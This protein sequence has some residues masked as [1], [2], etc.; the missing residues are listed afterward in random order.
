MQART[1]AQ[2]VPQPLPDTWDASPPRCGSRR[3]RCSS[4]PGRPRQP[5]RACSP[6]RCG[7]LRRWHL[8]TPPSRRL[9]RHRTGLRR[10]PPATHW[11]RQQATGRHQVQRRTAAAAAAPAVG[12]QRAAG[13]AA[14]AAACASVALAAQ[15]P[16]CRA[17][18]WQ[19]C[20][21]RICMV[22]S[23]RWLRCSEILAPLARAW[24]SGSGPLAHQSTIQM[25]TVRS[26]RGTTGGR[27]IGEVGRQASLCRLRHGG[28]AQNPSQRRL[29]RQR[30]R[31]R[32]QRLRRL[33]QRRRETSSSAQQ[34]LRY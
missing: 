32:R 15:R 3:H 11:C 16:S 8:R 19:R 2:A 21:R 7:T 9:D 26:T 28:T 18:A 29:Q 25:T 30:Q 31:L 14:A 6:R 12:R 24:A 34:R 4:S 17:A 33:L 22:S 10:P 23:Q 13:R 1:V 5:D 20:Q 27:P